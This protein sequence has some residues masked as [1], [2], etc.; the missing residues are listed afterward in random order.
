MYGLG[1][2]SACRRVGRAALALALLAGSSGSA[3]A[4]DAGA[5]GSGVETSASEVSGALETGSAGTPDDEQLFAGGPREPGVLSAEGSMIGLGTKPPPAPRGEDPATHQEDDA[6]AAL[7]ASVS[8]AA[9]VPE[10]AGKNA[11]PEEE[12]L[13]GPRKLLRSLGELFGLGRDP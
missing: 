5:L 13:G 8:G 12:S 11:A 7:V 10:P 3:G 4:Q 6:V 1:W 9:E 2:D